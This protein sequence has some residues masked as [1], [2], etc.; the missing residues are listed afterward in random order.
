LLYYTWRICE[1]FNLTLPTIKENFYDNSSYTIA[2]L[3]A[4]EQIRELE[5]AELAM[6][7]FVRKILK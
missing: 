5:E 2:R 7:K 6:G 3:L 4:Y 1:R